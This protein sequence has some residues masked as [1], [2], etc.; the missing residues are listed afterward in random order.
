MDEVIKQLLET[1]EKIQAAAGRK[2][3]PSFDAC[4]IAAGNLLASGVS[5]SAGTEIAAGKKK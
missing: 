2:G 4:L 5:P 1:A 3:S